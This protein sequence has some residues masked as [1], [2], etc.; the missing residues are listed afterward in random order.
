MNNRVLSEELLDS[1]VEGVNLNADT[2]KGL[3][4][5]RRTLL[6]FLRHFGCLF[7]RELVKDVRALSDS[8][9][10]FPQVLF[11]FIAT[12]GEGEKFFRDFW[13]EARAVA[14]ARRY[15]DAFAMSRG[16]VASV[17]MDPRIWIRGIEALL[18][19]NTVGI[20]RG[21]TLV[22]PGFFLVENNAIIA[23]YRSR[24]SADH[25]DLVTFS[26]RASERREE[27]SPHF[28]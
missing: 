17:M 15:Y 10:E 3:L 24:H 27:G 22:L 14:D 18:K 7:C 9:A 19:K 23:V 26:R 2:L 16:S 6:V 12:A 13:P 20:P 8:D 25:P 21:D 11:F 4:G 5:E 28:A 1:P